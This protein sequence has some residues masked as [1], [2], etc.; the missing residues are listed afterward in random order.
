MNT[1]RWTLAAAAVALL[2]ASGCTRRDEA[3]LNGRIEAYLTDLGPRVG[4]R[5]AELQV[6]E[7]QR[8]KAG[9]LLARIAAEEL[10]AAVARDAA[11]LASAE[12]RRLEL[13]RGTRQEQV[14]QGEARV[15]DAQA[16]LTLAE[17]NL[18]RVEALERDRIVSKA[19]LDRSRAERDR[20]RASLALQTKVLAELRAGARGEQ[21]QAGQ[22]EAKKAKAVLDQSR[23]QASFTEVRAP[24]DG[25]V[26]HRLRE[27]GT[28]LA[29]GQAILTL[30]REDTL[31]VKL[32]V[33]QPLQPRVKLG[34]ALRVV[35][36]DG[37]S[38]D[39]TLDEVAS[40]AEYTPK[41][42]ETR[43]ERVNLVYPA[44][45]HLARGWD[46]GLLPGTSVEVQIPLTGK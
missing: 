46:Q 38:L 40:E 2:S 31:W 34:M 7:G 24:F 12:A 35:T 33:P 5:L 15:G 26:V 42:V 43:E 27:V 13:D 6:R 45:I 28:V 18:R 44:R 41:M 17:D 8:V 37:R 32:Y 25:V 20:A 30:G 16:A 1:S 9:D 3:V 19:E 29:P 11:G 23:A 10:D 39:A 4:G 14:A 22:A 21:R 36:Q